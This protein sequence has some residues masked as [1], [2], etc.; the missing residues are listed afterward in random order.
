[1]DIPPEGIDIGGMELARGADGRGAGAER[2]AGGGVAAGGGIG[3]ISR[4]ERFMAVDC[5]RPAVEVWVRLGRAEVV[6]AVE[7][8]GVA[9]VP[10]V[11]VR[12]GRFTVA[13]AFVRA[14]PPSIGCPAAFITGRVGR[15][16]VGLPTITVDRV[17]VIDGGTGCRQ[18]GGAFITAGYAFHVFQPPGCQAHPYDGT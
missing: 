5:D 14:V 1:M 17:A 8:E 9:V 12:E 10:G 6:L 4:E 11:I 2:G 15:V 18:L 7:A 3:R 16:N 13:A